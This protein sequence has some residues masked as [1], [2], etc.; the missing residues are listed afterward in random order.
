MSYETIT[1]SRDSENN[2]V[3]ILTL[4]RPE[5][6]NSF[7]AQM[8]FDL[9]DAFEKADKDK[10]MRVIVMTGA[11]RA[12]CAGADISEG[13]DA[14]APVEVDE[15]TGIGRDLGGVLNLK[16]FD[17]DTPI[18][19]A[20]NGAAV[21]IGATMTIPMD[22]RIASTKSKFAFPF[23]RRGI[24]F[25]GA[26]SWFLPRLVGFAK[27]SEWILKANIIMA[28]EMLQAGFVSEVVEPEHVLPRA[29]ELAR[30]IAQNCSPSSIANNKRLL[31]AS[32]FG[33]ETQKNVPYQMHLMESK[34]LTQAFSSHDCQEGVKAFF[35]KRSPKFEDRKF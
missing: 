19:A 27:A 31:R 9:I 16:M 4:N 11:G 22:L 26:A 25:D 20:I 23:A 13:F 8:C 14:V 29:L 2:H 7:N 28:D 3:A 10:T 34:M 24:V 15:D 1:L 17:L 12:F 6:L 21:G 35:E 33:L 32:M 30:D 5:Q 18:I